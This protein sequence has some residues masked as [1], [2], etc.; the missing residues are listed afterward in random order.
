M[1]N[2]IIQTI[3]A[4]RQGQTEN[5]SWGAKKHLFFHSFAKWTIKMDNV[6]EKKTTKKPADMQPHNEQQANQKTPFEQGNSI[7]T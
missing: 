1:T 5:H 2:D 7:L 3:S 4:S 6:W